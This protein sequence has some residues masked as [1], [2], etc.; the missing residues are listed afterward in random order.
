MYQGL[1]VITYIRRRKGKRKKKNQDQEN[2][3]WKQFEGTQGL[4]EEESVA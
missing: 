2:M 1:K 4:W 3:K